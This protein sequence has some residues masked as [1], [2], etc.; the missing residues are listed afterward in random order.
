MHKVDFI[1]EEQVEPVIKDLTENE[2]LEDDF[3][4]LFGKMAGSAPCPGIMS[5]GGKL[6]VEVLKHKC[7]KKMIQ[8][9]KK[10]AQ[11]VKEVKKET[12]KKGE[13]TPSLPFPLYLTRSKHQSFHL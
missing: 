2:L 9:A 3:V 6:G 12:K 8:V 4:W 1:G 10:G 13:P 5:A 7:E 11:F